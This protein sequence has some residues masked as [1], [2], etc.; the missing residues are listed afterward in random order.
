[1]KYRLAAFADEAASDLAGQMAA[2]K[3]NG[4]KLL[5]IRGVDGLNIDQLSREKAREIRRRLDDEG[6]GVWSLGSPFG[7]IGI[8]EDFAPHLDS[9]RHSLELAEILGAGH[10]RLFSFY[11][12]TEVGPVLE[13]LSAFV[14]AAKGS[15]L[16]L[17]H[18]NE[19]EIYGDTA[20]KCLEIHRALPGLRA[21]FDP[22]NFI[23][24]GQDTK[25]AWELLSPYVEYMHIKD[26]L[27][28]G[29]VVP[30]GRGVGELPDLLSKYGGEVLTIEPH[31][32]VFEGFDK[33]ENEQKTQMPYTYPDARTAFKAATDALKEIIGGQSNGK[34]KTRNHRYGQHGQRSSRVLSEQRV[35]QG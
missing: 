6:L 11:G 7:K 17:C 19:K 33:L 24:C 1:M 31:L 3:G 5:E 9:F 8:H 12:A 30:A 35:P 32:T 26:A 25:E 18:E 15:D 16:I 22:A 10:F 27:W 4:I 2:M 23:Q 29:S 28:D 21:V 20:I 13:R 34:A 14:E